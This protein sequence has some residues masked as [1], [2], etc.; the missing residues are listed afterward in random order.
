MKL[1]G[2]R[3]ES[4]LI[5][6]YCFKCVYLTKVDFYLFIIVVVVKTNDS[7]FGLIGN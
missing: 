2:S 3:F 1:S 6:I 7:T 5:C 4:F